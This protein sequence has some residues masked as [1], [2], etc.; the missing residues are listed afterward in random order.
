MLHHSCDKVRTVA[1]SHLA[2][3]ACDLR[4]F[5]D[6][7]TFLRGAFDMFKAGVPISDLDPVMKI[8][9]V[10]TKYIHQIKLI[11]RPVSRR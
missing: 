4:C 7:I 1:S 9:K 10:L 6:D 5:K 11:D 3:L 8:L 2:L